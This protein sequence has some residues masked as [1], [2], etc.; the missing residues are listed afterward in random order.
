MAERIPLRN[1]WVLFLYTANLVQFRDRF[2]HQVEVARD[3]S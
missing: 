3:L 1:I 2:D